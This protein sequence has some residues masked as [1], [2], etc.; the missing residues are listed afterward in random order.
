MTT[1]TNRRTRRAS[2]SSTAPSARR[3][4]AASSRG[5]AA[6]SKDIVAL[7]RSLR[8]A[9]T[10]AGLSKADA[11]KKIGV[12]FVTL[13]AWENERRSD[14][15]SDENLAKAARVYRTTVESLRNGT[16]AQKASPSQPAARDDKTASKRTKG[17]RRGT[18]AKKA[19]ADVP[20]MDTLASPVADRADRGGEVSAAV[21]D[22]GRS[23]KAAS[24]PSVPQ[25]LYARSLRVLADLA[26]QTPLPPSRLAAAQE[27][28]TAPELFQLF[29]A[30]SPQPLSD[31]DMLAV[32]DSAG[33][34]VRSFMAARSPAWS[35][36]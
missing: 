26:E 18:R 36:S 25:Q 22:T 14:K 32:V 4:G 21:T 31:D 20:V 2:S 7:S 23:R 3:K 10:A 33:D 30:F 29:A 19:R 13:Y 5:S 8:D 27:A 6:P 24:S 1:R 11:A 35:D 34:A 15:P 12:H 28:L 17:T 9:R 16:D